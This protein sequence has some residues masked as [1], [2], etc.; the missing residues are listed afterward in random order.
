MSDRRGPSWPSAPYDDD[1]A[2]VPDTDVVADGS[3]HTV[4]ATQREA[5]GPVG[6]ERAH[7]PFELGPRQ[8]RDRRRAA[9]RCRQ[10]VRRR[11]PPVR[12]ATRR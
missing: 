8:D 1:F 11:G 10:S 3:Q 12:R 9:A 7:R 2:P 4:L 5:H 6:L